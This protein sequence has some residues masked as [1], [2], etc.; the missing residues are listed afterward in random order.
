MYVTW[1]TLSS[2][3]QATGVAMHEKL[4]QLS[5]NICWKINLTTSCLNG[6]HELWLL[7]AKYYFPRM[8]I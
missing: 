7:H 8:G 4:F 2:C 1:P 3:D 5:E 6:K